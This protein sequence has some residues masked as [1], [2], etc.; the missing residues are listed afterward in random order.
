MGF[1]LPDGF[2]GHAIDLRG[3]DRSSLEHSTAFWLL[4]PRC[5]VCGLDFV[6]MRGVSTADGLTWAHCACLFALWADSRSSTC[7]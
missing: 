4:K 1:H 3:F 2:H 5:C 7:P 6:A